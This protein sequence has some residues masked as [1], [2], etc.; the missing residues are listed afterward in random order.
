[1]QGLYKSVNRGNAVTIYK[2]LFSKLPHTDTSPEFANG[3][4]NKT[5]STSIFI[6]H[7]C[8]SKGVGGFGLVL[9]VCFLFGFFFS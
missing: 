3:K 7:D 5:P 9:G 1:M 8:F 4:Q 6:S 2:Q